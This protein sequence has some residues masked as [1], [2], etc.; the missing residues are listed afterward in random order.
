MKINILLA[1]LLDSKI[2]DV[3]KGKNHFNSMTCLSG[4]VVY[5]HGWLIYRSGE[6]FSLRSGTSLPGRRSTEPDVLFF[7]RDRAQM[8]VHC[9]P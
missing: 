7:I 2:I 5:S 4:L 3:V 9:F 8:G 6:D 1:L